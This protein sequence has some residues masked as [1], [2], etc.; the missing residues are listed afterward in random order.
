MKNLSIILGLSFSLHSFAAE[1][2][3]VCNDQNGHSVFRLQLSED[4]SISQLFTV[5]GDSSVL[6]AGTKELKI[7]EGESTE[8]VA[9]YAGKTN[10]GLSLA[11]L[12]NA[13]K[14]QEL[15]TFEILEVSAFYQKQKG[16]ILSGNTLLLCGRR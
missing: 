10:S 13:Q 11:L 9:T 15:E 7:Q 2:T 12:F 1:T 8:V 16:D 3:L 5:I 6:A 14:A 4:R